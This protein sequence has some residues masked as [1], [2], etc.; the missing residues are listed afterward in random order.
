MRS[1][2]SR[3][4]ILFNFIL[5][6]LYIIV[7]TFLESD[8][9]FDGASKSNGEYRIYKFTFKHVV[10]IR[11]LFYFISCSRRFQIILFACK[12]KK[13]KSIARNEYGSYLSN[14]LLGSRCRKMELFFKNDDPVRIRVEPNKW[15]AYNNQ[16]FTSNIY[17]VIG[18]NN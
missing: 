2:K 6:Y 1:S 10:A 12:L 5:N 8:K 4:I 11:R 17:E 7:S 13:K 18:S 3:Y 9:Q 14:S 16:S 15:V